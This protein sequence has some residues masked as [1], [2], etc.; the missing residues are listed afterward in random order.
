[1]AIINLTPHN[2][3]LCAE[4]GAVIADIPS[5]GSAR[6]EQTQ[7]EAIAVDG[8]PV[9]VKTPSTYGAVVGLPPIEEMAGDTYVVSLFTAQ[10]L[11][12]MADPRAALVLVPGTGPADG[13]IRDNGRIVGV[14]CLVQVDASAAKRALDKA[15]NDGWNSG[16]YYG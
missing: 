2:L 5:S 11:A 12:A 16:K 3:T 9:P 14:T 1:M 13:A 8:I 6:V 15:Y 10:A 4:D 7:G